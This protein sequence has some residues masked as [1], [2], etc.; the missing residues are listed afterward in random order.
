MPHLAKLLDAPDPRHLPEGQ[1][2]EQLG[3][4]S[5]YYGSQLRA[6]GN[7]KAKAELGWR[8]A[9]PSWRDGFRAVFA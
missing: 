9:F 4:Q 5:V 7:A 2:A 8:L 1:A 3:V 6:A